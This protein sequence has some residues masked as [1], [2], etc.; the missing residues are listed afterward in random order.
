MTITDEMLDA[1]LDG[2][3]GDEGWRQERE[4]PIEEW[5]GSM[6]LAIEAAL[7]AMPKTNG[8]FTA[9]R[10]PQGHVHA[11]WRGDR[12]VLLLATGAERN[13]ENAD[14]VVGMLNVAARMV[15]DA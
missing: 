4:S 3:F 10:N 6:T 13:E 12:A 8:P 5:R 11:I 14:A 1:A 7:A 2:W 15:S 9:V